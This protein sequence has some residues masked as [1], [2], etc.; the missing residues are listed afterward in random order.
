MDNFVFRSPTKIIFGK[1]TEKLV[2]QEVKAFG[3]KVLLHYGTGSIKKT[4]LY[5]VIVNSLKESGVDFLELGG[6]LPNPRLGLV[7]QGIELCR[8]ENVGFILAVGGG[9]AIDSAKAI[10]V[11]VPYE[12]D[13]WDFY[14]KTAIPVKTLPT[15]VVL[16]IAAAGSETSKSS[17]I[18]KEDGWYKK[19]LNEEITRPEFAIMNPELTYTLPA[20]QTSCGVADILAHILERYFTTTQ[21]V[22]LT[23]RMCE[24]LM[25]TVIRTA[26]LA[27]KDPL[28]Y[29]IRAEIM[30][31]GSIAHNDLLSTGRV[32]DWASHMI[33]HE[34][35]ALFDVAHGAGLAVVFPAWMKYVYMNDINRFIKFANRVFD[36]EIDL[37]YPKRTVLEGI[38]RLKNFFIDMGLPVSLEE[39]GIPREKINE[40]ASKCTNDGTSTVGSFVKIGKQDVMK[41]FELA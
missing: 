3:S 22:D 2:G 29:G 16:T 34:L 10:A 8:K 23:D 12:G 28:D 14:D 19:G 32:G 36:V 39:L 13:V 35:S 11:G 7:K 37:D 41:I 24:G 5:D 9:S 38:N 33:E 27:L 15:G 18:T 21:E 17:V 4:G 40:M 30:W 31:A 25:R 1:E 20:Y 26:P 6:A